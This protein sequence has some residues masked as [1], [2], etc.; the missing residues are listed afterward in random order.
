MAVLTVGPGKAYSTVRA[1]AAVAQDGDVI[2][3]SAGTYI[4]DGAVIGTRVTIEGVGGLARF[5]AT[6]AP[7]SSLGLF[8]TTADV[9][10]RNVEIFGV[11]TPGGVAAAILSQAGSLTIANSVIHDN[12]AG[13]VT[14]GKGGAV[15]ITDTEIARNGTA[16][17][18]G[19]NLAVAQAAT[20]TLTRD[21]IHDAVAAPEVTSLANTNTFTADR[22]SQANGNGPA[23]I[24]LPNGG[25]TIITASAI[26]KGAASTSPVLVQIGTGSPA[27]G[28]SVTMTGNTL[29][30]TLGS[31]PT[32]FVADAG[33]AVKLTASANTFE[34]GTS[35]SVQVSGGSNTA[36]KTA[37]GDM[38][39]TASPLGSGPIPLTVPVAT[40]AG[41]AQPGQLVLRVSE[42]AFQGDAQFQLTLDGAPVAGTLTA[43]ASHGAGQ[44][45]TFTVAGA[46]A[47]GAH[48]V[49]VA[50]VNNRTGPGPGQNRALYVDGMS[51]NGQEVTGAKATLTANGTALLT[52]GP[53]STKVPVSVNLSADA[54][55]G[56]AMA[57]ITIDGVVR[58]GVQTV[59][60]SHA[61]G[62][63]Q[64][65]QF[66][67][68]LAPGPHSGAATLLNGGAGRALYLDSLDVAGAH[69]ALAGPAVTSGSGSFAFTV[70]PPAAAN[71][72]MFVTA[73]MARPLTDLLPYQA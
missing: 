10:F 70:A 6:R 69:T 51:F 39:N 67:L 48:T 52:T 12:Q 72:A 34:G 43:V 35:G 65:M 73:G 40:P 16:D 30:S 28:S 54:A 20:L 9:V 58:G 2:D 5:V 42:D 38:I 59:T 23:A 61:A 18:R 62:R 21:Y 29:I 32:T 1:A 27:A 49:G 60:A 66:L 45:Q 56:D 22:I 26:E 50:L 4:D 3:V 8:V 71:G 19:A 33:P 11:A 68:D 44:S 53:V 36:A 64:A 57:F 55:G 46:F 37:S 17:G 24:V 31:A 7:S 14:K 63:T 13:V 25:V 15:T 47:P 41:P